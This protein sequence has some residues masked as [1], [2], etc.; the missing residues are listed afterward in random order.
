MG[1][2]R[3]HHNGQYAQSPP[4]DARHA[5][6]VVHLRHKCRVNNISQRNQP[7][8]ARVVDPQLLK[9][10]PANRLVSDGGEHPRSASWCSA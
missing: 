7:H 5:V 3:G 2:L 10:L 6:K 1:D 4:E 8:P 9:D